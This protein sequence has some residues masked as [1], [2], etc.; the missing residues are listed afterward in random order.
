MIVSEVRRSMR[1]WKYETHAALII[2]RWRR[3]DGWQCNGF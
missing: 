2:E 1:G 3:C